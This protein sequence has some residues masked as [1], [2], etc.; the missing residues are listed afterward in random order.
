[1][2]LRAIARWLRKAVSTLEHEVDGR[3]G[4]RL[5]RM[6]SR[7][8]LECLEDRLAPALILWDGGP[9]G[10]GT[11]W[12]VPANWDG[13]VPPGVFDNAE[14]GAAFCGRTIISANNVTILG[15]TSA[16]PLT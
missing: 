6:S 5:G 1:M 10:T 15:V 16:A 3:R 8:A 14:I 11:D 12:Q 2:S 9:T 13:D 7:L 4:A